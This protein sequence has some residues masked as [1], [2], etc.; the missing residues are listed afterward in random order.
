MVKAEMSLTKIR[1]AVK[2][3]PVE[4]RIKLLEELEKSTW[5]ER[6]R[7]TVARIRARAKK[8]PISD[9]EIRQIVEDVRQENH[10]KRRR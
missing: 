8:D 1:K 10:E 5:Q 7:K 9:E 3:L 6:M 2:N 4:Q